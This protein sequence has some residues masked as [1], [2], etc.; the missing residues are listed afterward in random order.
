MSEL[1]EFCTGAWDYQIDY[2]IGTF[3]QKRILLLVRVLQEQHTTSILVQQYNSIN[4][5]YSFNCASVSD[6]TLE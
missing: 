5:I 1:A 2:Q 4:S 3:F 6:S